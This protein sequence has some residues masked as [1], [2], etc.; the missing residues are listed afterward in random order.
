MKLCLKNYKNG[1]HYIFQVAVM[2][3]GALYIC[4]KFFACFCTW[5]AIITVCFHQ[6]IQLHHVT[7]SSLKAKT[8]E[9]RIGAIQQSLYKVKNFNTILVP[10]FSIDLVIRV[11]RGCSLQS[12]LK[13][14][15]CDLSGLRDKGK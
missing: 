8:S 12:V 11:V 13:I 10:I 3:S 2:L 7:P 5:D 9:F 15:S 14:I 1:Y 4:N 6:L